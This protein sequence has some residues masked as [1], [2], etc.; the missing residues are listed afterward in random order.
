MKRKRGTKK[1]KR[2]KGKVKREG[3]M[4][5]GFCPLPSA[6]RGSLSLLRQPDGQGGASIEAAR[7]LAAVVVLRP[8]F[9][10]ADGV[11]SIGADTTADKVLAHRGGSPVAQRQIVLGR[12]DVA[13]VP[14]D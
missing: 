9:A 11:Q 6:L 1:G 13:G 3:Q 7:L 10:V 12:A 4:A 5:I 2:Q 8:L 14:F